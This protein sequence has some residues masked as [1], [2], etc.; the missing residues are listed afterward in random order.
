[1]ED[2]EETLHLLPL[3]R[4]LQPPLNFIA[5]ELLRYSPYLENPQKHE[6]S[7]IQPWAILDEIF[8]GWADREKLA[9][10]YNGEFPSQSYNNPE[11]IREIGSQV[12]LW[13]KTWKNTTL[14]MGPFMDAFAIYDNRDIHQEPKTHILDYQQA[15]EIMTS[16]IYNESQNLNWAVSEKLGVILDSR[17]VPLVTA[18]PGILL[19]FEKDN[20]HPEN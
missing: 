11:I 18:S 17:Y 7:K 19:N 9:T 3:I 13:K 6:I 16:G 2:I 10:Y 12:E 1:V 14:A 15:K 8:P 4:H 5:L 20:P